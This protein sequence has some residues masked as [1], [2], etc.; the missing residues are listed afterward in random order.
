[1]SQYPDDLGT[2]WSD[3]PGSDR[4]KQATK[5][6]LARTTDVMHPTVPSR[7]PG[8]TDG[9]LAP[10]VPQEQADPAGLSALFVRRHASFG[11]CRPSQIVSTTGGSGTWGPDY[12]GQHW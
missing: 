10:A 1:M 8:A 12:H 4:A 7:H 11:T 5:R 9:V 2:W 6:S 3:F